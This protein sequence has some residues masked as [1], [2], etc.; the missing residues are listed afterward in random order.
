M[1]PR[2]S[3]SRSRSHDPQGKRALFET[4]VS[5][6]RD[7]IRAGAAKEGKTA[8]YSTG[9]HERGSVVVACSSCQA[10]T[11]ISVTDVLMRLAVVSAWVPV[12]RHSHWMKCPAC[13][14]R[15]W[16]QVRWMG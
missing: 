15:R 9:P 1:T 11:R 7:T 2:P 14:E 8:L 16:C 3:R 10:R 12:L 13:G 4:P 5:A 6:A